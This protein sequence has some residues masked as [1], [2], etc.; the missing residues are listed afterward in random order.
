MNTNKCEVLLQLLLANTHPKQPINTPNQ[1][2]K[3]A[4]H[5]KRN[6]VQLLNKATL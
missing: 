1:L 3:C 5:K 6:N 2:V 4:L